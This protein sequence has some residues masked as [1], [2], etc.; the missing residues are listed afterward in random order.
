MKTFKILIC[1][2][3]M[4]LVAVSAAAQ[5]SNRDENGKIL[6]GPY[7]TNGLWDNWF[8]GVG[9]GVNAFADFKHDYK[10]G[11]APAVDVYV[12]K[13]FSPTVGMRIGYQGLSG[14][15]ES[16]KVWNLGGKTYET[17][18][19]AEGYGDLLWNISNTIGGY[20]SDRFWDVIPYAHA[21]YMRL[22]NCEDECAKYHDSGYRSPNVYDN[23][24]VGGAG[25]LNQFRISN[26]VK[27]TLDLREQIYSSRYHY[28]KEGGVAHNM[29]ALLGVQ[30][31]LGK[32][33]W[34]RFNQDLVAANAALAAANAQ[35]EKL[36]NE[37]N[38]APKEKI[39]EVIKEVPA[40]QALAPDTELVP[41]ALGIAPITLYYEI[42]ISDL[43][44]TERQ[45]LDHYVHD[46]INKDPKRVFYLTGTAD[47]GTG[48]QE[49]NEKLSLAR[50]QKV[51]N[52]LVNEYG[53]SKD[54]L[55]LKANKIVNE[56]SDP[57]LD[58]SVIIEH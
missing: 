54:R 8:V 39:V 20:R 16:T 31:G 50:V 4:A 43:N 13:W 30:V 41:L 17:L 27:I 12:G 56:H 5:E 40:Q 28:W 44:F 7:Q 37:L 3:A 38:K 51:I 49:I 26:R 22:F 2:V 10:P 57:R 34:S 47:E 6:R 15:S 58:R 46:V 21:G 9:G 25:I 36:K 29:S 11:I 45:H 23:E 52:L 19:F 18:D 53:I 33:T 48:T 1:T 55:V 35:I 42:N 14:K 32:T 24:L